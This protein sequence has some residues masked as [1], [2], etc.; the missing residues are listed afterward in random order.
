MER[1]TEPASE[2]EVSIDQE[3]IA[4]SEEETARGIETAGKSPTATRKAE[5]ENL[6]FLAFQAL[7]RMDEKKNPQ[8]LRSKKKR[9]AAAK[10]ARRSRKQNG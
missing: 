3:F 9:R 2:Q 4:T 6:T 7:K 5:Q 10:V 8:K 1:E